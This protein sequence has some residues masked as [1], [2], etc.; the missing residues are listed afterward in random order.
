MA[1]ACAVASARASRRPPVAASSVPSITARRDARSCVSAEGTKFSAED[2]RMR[3]GPIFCK[4]IIGPGVQRGGI[5]RAFVALLQAQ[6]R[7][8]GTP[9][10][11]LPP[12]F[13]RR[14]PLQSPV[15]QPLVANRKK[16]G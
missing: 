16:K 10:V 7:L 5:F 4:F 1:S 2:G 9:S 6:I 11:T 13:T 15:R 14:E 3:F 12:Y 8:S